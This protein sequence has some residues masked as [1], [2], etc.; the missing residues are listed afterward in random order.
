MAKKKKDEQEAIVKPLAIISAAITD[1]FCNYS[2]EVRSGTGK[3]DIHS[4]KGKGIVDADM[5]IAFFALSV[6]LAVIDD[7]FKH[8]GETI[9]NIK[10]LRA[11]ELAAKYNVTG[12]KIK[13]GEENESVILVGT[14]E[15]SCSGQFMSLETPKI[16]LD[17]HSSY[18]W[19]QELKEAVDAA[20]FEVEEYRNGKYTEAEQTEKADPTQLK[21]SEK[22]IE[23][24][25]LD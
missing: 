16:P 17:E 13:G 11:H 19:V 15:V 23:D 25:K 9:T 12:F 14:K 3:G 4:I 22:D 21:I 6:H 24:G 20:R 7:I 2:Y 18:K 10:A 8:S 5:G 1:E